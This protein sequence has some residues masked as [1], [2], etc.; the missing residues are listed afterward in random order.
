MF[1]KNGIMKIIAVLFCL[2]FVV[3]GAGFYFQATHFDNRHENNQ[4]AYERPAKGVFHDGDAVHLNQPV[5]VCKTAQDCREA[6]DMA[7]RMTLGEPSPGDI[8]VGN[9]WFEFRKEA[10]RPANDVVVL[11][12]A[13]NY[14]RVRITSGPDAGFEGYVFT[15][16][17]EDAAANSAMDS[18]PPQS[19][20]G[21]S[22]E[23]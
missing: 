7:R 5:H 23:P 21:V 18:E 1:H 3:V 15:L 9:E 4:R 13:P 10:I 20:E 12:P 19:K 14:S 16:E 6:R 17:L 22:R 2:M 8:R 11:E